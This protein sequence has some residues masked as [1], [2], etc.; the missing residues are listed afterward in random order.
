MDL[1]VDHITNTR[2][3]PGFPSQF[4]LHFKSFSMNNSC[5]LCSDFDGDVAA[6]NTY[7]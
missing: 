3:P 4:P 2:T 7:R 1:T 6:F 5:S